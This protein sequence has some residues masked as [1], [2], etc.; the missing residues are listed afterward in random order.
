MTHSVWGRILHPLPLESSQKILR[1]L[2]PKRVVPMIGR[3]SCICHLRE[4]CT[5]MRRAFLRQGT[6]EFA[7][8]PLAWLSKRKMKFSQSSRLW[9]SQ[10]QTSLWRGR[11]TE[12]GTFQEAGLYGPAEIQESLCW[13]VSQFPPCEKGGLGSSLSPCIEGQRQYIFSDQDVSSYLHHLCIG[14]LDCL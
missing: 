6:S 12:K 7:L 2:S 11:N 8:L 10:T 1:I 13:A 3:Q 5:E 9:A 14:W 4:F